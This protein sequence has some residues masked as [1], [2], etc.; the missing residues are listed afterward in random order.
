VKPLGVMAH[1][2]DT[3]CCNTVLNYIL[4]KQ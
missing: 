3:A 1:I 2:L 4:L